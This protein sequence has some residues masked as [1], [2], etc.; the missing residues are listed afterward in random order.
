MGRLFTPLVTG[1]LGLLVGA[2]LS[3]VLIERMLLTTPPGPWQDVVL[4][5][6]AGLTGLLFAVVGLW[7]D[8]AVDTNQLAVTPL[9]HLM[10]LVYTVTGALLGAVV[11]Y[12]LTRLTGP[13]A[14]ETARLFGGFV[15][16]IFAFAGFD[17]GR[18]AASTRIY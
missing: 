3:G 7:L 2:Y 16:A 17:K 18:Q 15:M 6:F 5:G 14:P 8:G 13:L 10:I 9:R 12:G 4:V 1:I 11:F